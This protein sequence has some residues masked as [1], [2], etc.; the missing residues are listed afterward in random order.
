MTFKDIFPRLSRT[1]SFNFQ[2]QS[3]FPGLSRSWNFQEKKSRTLQEAWEPCFWDRKSFSFCEANIVLQ[4]ILTAIVVRL[5]SLVVR[6]WTCSNQWVAGSTRAA[7]TCNI[8]GKFFTRMCL[9]S[10][11]INLVP[12]QTG[13]VTVGQTSHWTCVTDN[14]G[15]STYGFTALEGEMSTLP[16]LQQS[17]VQIISSDLWMVKPG[18]VL[19]H[20]D[21]GFECY[22]QLHKWLV[23]QRIR[24]KLLPRNRKVPVT[25][26]MSQRGM[27]Q[28]WKRRSARR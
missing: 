5:G 9:S 10:S 27:S 28:R 26:D 8:L 15:L 11:S 23:A 2:D 21:P 3:D 7:I 1:L 16:M 14:I 12:V 24:P 18:I 4:F 13:E 17:M 22:C 19:S 25:H 20:S 6:H